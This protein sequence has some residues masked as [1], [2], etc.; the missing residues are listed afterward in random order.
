MP[1]L[2][3][4]GRGQ[5]A[6]AT[7]IWPGFVDALAALLMVVIFLL[8][9]FTVAQFYLSTELSGSEGQVAR[10]QSRLDTALLDLDEAN[11][12]YDELSVSFQQQSAELQATILARD[13]LRDELA[14]VQTGRDEALE[15]LDEALA[16][17]EA[18]RLDRDGLT[19]ELV[20]AAQ[21]I[22]ADR[23]TLES[24]VREISSLQADV[25]ALRTVRDTLELE[26]ASLALAL[27]MAETDA[28]RLASELEETVALTQEEIAALVIQ[29]DTATALAQQIDT[30]LDETRSTAGELERRLQLSREDVLQLRDFL[31]ARDADIDAL[32][33]GLAAS[34]ASAAE[35]D[36]QVS[37]ERQRTADLTEDLDAALDQNATLG[38][39]LRLSQQE[40]DA[41]LSEITGLRDRSLALETE[42]SD[43]EERTALA[44]RTIDEQDIRIDRLLADLSDRQTDLE[45]QQDVAD[46][47]TASIER[48]TADVVGLREDVQRLRAALAASEA[49]VDERDQEIVD[50]EARLNQALL[51][52]VEEL[53]GYRSDFFG[54]LRQILGSREGIEVAGDRFVF[55]S[56]VLFGSGSARLEPQGRE[57]LAE[58]ADTLI[59][60]ADE[61]PPGVDWVLRVDGHTDRRPL[62]ETSA[63]ETNWELSTARATEVVRFLEDQGIPPDRLAAAGFGQWQP[64]DDG[65]DEA[66]FARNRRIE[67]R[68]DQ[69]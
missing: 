69:R 40:R 22:E 10:L 43:A 38:L 39:Q 35:L 2:R 32:T 66:A 65:D 46:Q 25:S 41:L 33:A 48:L 17:I 59:A 68:L 42:L 45:A 30:E 55:Q 15:R 14:D 44:Q 37:E 61:L 12:D 5:G 29:R 60:L 36:R 11:S 7:N 1:S 26:V 6:I 13:D 50:L 67:M 23:Q 56:E 34:E 8:L 54:E 16:G 62:V 18:L 3:S 47:R 58:F 28:A 57:R 31:A 27:R 19:E 9:V 21:R 53:S 64:V 63:F 51:R 49:G 4:N 20:G 24:Q 52:Q